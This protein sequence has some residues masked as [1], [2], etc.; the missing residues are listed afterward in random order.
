MDLKLEKVFSLFLRKNFYYVDE[1]EVKLQLES[2]P[3]F[4]SL[5][6]VTDTLDYLDIEH[7]AISVPKEALDQLPDCFLAMIDSG[8]ARQNNLVAINKNK[9]KIEIHNVDQKKTVS[10]EE[11]KEQWTGVVVAIEPNVAQKGSGSFL[12]NILNLEGVLSAL[13]IILALGY[14]VLQGPSIV[15]ALYLITAIG[16]MVV[17]VLILREELGVGSRFVERI[18]NATQATSCQEVL[19]SAGAKFYKNIGLSDLALLFFFTYVFSVLFNLISVDLLTYVNAISIPV[20]IYTV[21]Y[22]AIKVKKWCVLCLTLSA[23]LV[24]QFVIGVAFNGGFPDFAIV[25]FTNFILVGVL[26]LVAW[27]YVKPLLQS[28]KEGK[29]SQRDL[30]KFKKDGRIFNT[31]LNDGDSVINQYMPD[32][33]NIVVG[34]SDAPI[35]LIAVTNPMCGFCKPAFEQYDKIL[36]RFKD[37]VSVNF[38]FNVFLQDKEGPGFILAKRWVELYE[39]KGA[40]ETLSSMREWFTNKNIESWKRTYGMPEK[41]DDL[42]VL[43]NHKNWSLKNEINYTPA[44]ILKGQIFPKEYEL[45]DLIYFIDDFAPQ[46]AEEMVENG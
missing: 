25:G 40:E 42:S 31:L 30:L 32:D 41:A 23:I 8:E 10:V 18:C 46:P 17:S 22:Q 35:K 44:T 36:S 4:P 6:S 1:K 39:Q 24:A 12:G 15:S 43:E 29:E 27:F 13:A 37:Q 9:G 14:Y 11:F 2:H 34:S 19:N 5:R 7:V 45:S 16:G 20:V 33:L 21:L 28:V 38:K 26:A 3:D